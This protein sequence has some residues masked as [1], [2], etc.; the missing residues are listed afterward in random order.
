MF[1]A[2]I[3]IGTSTIHSLS[4]MEDLDGKQR[5]FLS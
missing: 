1:D 5:R 4:S 2:R 3:W